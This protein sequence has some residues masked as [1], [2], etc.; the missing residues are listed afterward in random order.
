LFFV[1]T[2]LG[3]RK[4]LTWSLKALAKSKR[5][6]PDFPTSVN[7]SL[8]NSCKLR[9]RKAPSPR[10]A[11]EKVAYTFNMPASGIDSQQVGMVLLLLN[12]KA[13]ATYSGT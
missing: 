12:L 3:A 2:P 5:N 11:H 6:I 8:F 7:P 13:L 9:A 10:E 1:K 4:Y